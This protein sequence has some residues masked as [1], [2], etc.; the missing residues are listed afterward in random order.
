M[1]PSSQSFISRSLEETEK[2]GEK[3]SKYLS[4][5]KAAAFWGDLG[6]GKTTLI[7]SIAKYLGYLSDDVNS[8]TFIYLNV[9]NG[10][11]LI[12]HFDLYRMKGEKEFIH[13]G[14]EE[15]LTS[16]A[17]TLI[18]WPERISS[19]LPEKTLHIKLRHMDETTREFS[20]SNE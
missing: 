1:K 20:W 2:L 5:G 10:K 14:F 19:L 6:S 16:D 3:L 9:Y 7:K 8:P 17:I 12:Y 11:L 4:P 15:Y 18:E 13:M